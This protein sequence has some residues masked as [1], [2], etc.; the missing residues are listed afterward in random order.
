MLFPTILLCFFL[1]K[2]LL[3]FPHLSSKRHLWVC[4]L[5]FIRYSKHMVGINVLVVGLIFCDY[6]WYYTFT[7]LYTCTYGFFLV[8]YKKLVIPLWPYLGVL[9]Y[10]FQKKNIVFCFW[11]SFLSLQTVKT[12]MKCSI[13][14]YFIWVY[15]VCKST[16]TC[17]SR[18]Y[19]S[20]GVML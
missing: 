14:L 6:L 8:W 3:L 18:L 15:S 1:S 20:R 19:I 7:S 13:M 9:G 10:N 2:R 5:S 11:G 12:L 17:Y 4:L 16:R